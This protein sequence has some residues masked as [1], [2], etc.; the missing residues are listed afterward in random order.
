MEQRYSE[1]PK[2]STSV[3]GNGSLSS[4]PSSKNITFQTNAPSASIQRGQVYHTL[5]K[6]DDIGSTKKEKQATSDSLSF[7]KTLDERVSS[8]IGII[9]TITSESNGMNPR[10]T[11]NTRSTE[12][13]DDHCLETPQNTTEALPGVYHVLQEKKEADSESS[14]IPAE[15][16]EN[17]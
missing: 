14:D 9:Q 8:E 17:H 13:D 4:L 5:S 11:A 7:Q 15:T 3:N 2:S 6:D 10:E 1:S 12:P 16:T